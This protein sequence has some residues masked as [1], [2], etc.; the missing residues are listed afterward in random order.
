MSSGDAE[1]LAQLQAQV[2][3][4]TLA[5]QK[6]DAYTEGV[7][8]Q[9]EQE[10]RKTEESA[11]LVRQTT[12]RELLEFCHQYIDRR[13]VVETD[14]GK[15]TR[16]SITD[17]T[18]KLCPLFLEPWEDFEE[19]QA[20]AFDTMES[21]LHPVDSDPVREFSPLLHIQNLGQSWK[22]TIA[23]ELDLVSFQNQMVENFVG[24]VASSLASEVNFA[25]TSHVLG[26][27]PGSLVGPVQNPGTAVAPVLDPKAEKKPVPQPVGAD[28]LCVFRG[29]DDTAELLLI[30]EYKAPHKLTKEVLRVALQ[31]QSIINVTDVR[32][33]DYIPQEP[34]AKF[35]HG[36]QTLVSMAAA[37]TYDY[38]LRSGCTHGCIV[39]GESIVFVKV[40]E[41][42]PTRLLYYSTEPT[43]DAVHGGSGVF[44]HSK[45]SI[46][47]LSS[48]CLMA[49]QSPP[50]DQGWIRAAKAKASTWTVDH[51]KFWTETPEK[52]RE[53]QKKAD[54]ADT[55]YRGPNLLFSDRSPYL[56][57]K[58]KPRK[59]SWGCKTPTKGARNDHEDS[60]PEE[61][62]HDNMGSP[63][64][65]STL[66]T[67]HGQHGKPVQQASRGSAAAGKQQQRQYCTQ[68]CI[69]GLVQR[70]AIDE[71][72]PNAR[73]HPRGK[74]GD[75]HSL[76]KP[77]LRDLLRQQLARTMDEDCQNL[78][79]SGA[80]G[81]LF[82]LSLAEQGYTFVGKATIDRFVPCLQHEG[83]IYH[84]LRKLQGQLI[85]VCL[86]NID[87]DIPWY[88]LG[89]ELVHMLL[90][91][92]GGEHI[93][94]QKTEEHA[95]Q[96]E[97]FET[98]IAAYGVQHEDMR[99]RNMLWNQEIGRVLFI[100]FERS[101]TFRA[102][103][104]SPKI[105]SPKPKTMTTDPKRKATGKRKPLEE[106]SPSHL[107]LNRTGATPKKPAVLAV[108][109]LKNPT[110]EAPSQEALIQDHDPLYHEDLV[111]F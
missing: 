47:R 107:K 110:Q 57:R 79:L 85:P 63:R 36:A 50:R 60:D 17:P 22:R 31:G 71:S 15:T 84:R 83:G 91:S 5:K 13:F 28:Q 24:M 7:E 108:S 8:R 29:K 16:G 98:T 4:L 1:K 94:Y 40:K 80:R 102:Q 62:G 11:K 27:N 95:Q 66:K 103:A 105:M 99:S 44:H 106:L 78:R 48:F 33:Q 41:E 38:L 69:L 70:R 65:S 77:V 88:G 81:M 72:C 58:T 75:T 93:P 2:E 92:Y 73:S 43:L 30:E 6:A 56:T 55:S 18:G 21:Q 10:K 67:S 35:L 68:S 9:L 64:K 100:D 59:L 53:M 74:R 76:T 54:R 97:K 82:K 61:E 46:A 14:P 96:A 23:S 3:A 37:Q 101:T 26:Q 89:V 51:E 52:V 87:L 34:N 39:T 20:A 19:Q 25:N 86:G 32:D 90:M 49:F 45:T 111:A 42:D 104:R 12:L 109:P